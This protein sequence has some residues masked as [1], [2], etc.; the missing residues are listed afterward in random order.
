MIFAH[1]NDPQ[2]LPP[3]ELFGNWMLA[4]VALALTAGLAWI[5]LA[6]LYKTTDLKLRRE[7]A[8]WTAIALGILLAMASWIT[9]QSVVEATTK[10][11]DIR[12]HAH[13]M[14]HGGQVAM[15]GDY[16]AELARVESGEYRLW[17]SDRYR[18]SIG[19]KFFS[20]TMF[21]RDAKTAALGQG[22]PMDAGLDGEYRLAFLPRDKKSVQI[23]MKYPAGT[24][25][26][27]FVFD[28]TRGKRTMKGWCGTP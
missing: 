25:K 11:V 3:S 19:N 2:P 7:L 24:I 28:E 20:A 14:G 18:R 8:A 12:E 13:F 6:P 10:P 26:L 16:H 22:Y 27:N 15:W 5:S 1:G 17:L 4:M 9:R 21:E 23:Q